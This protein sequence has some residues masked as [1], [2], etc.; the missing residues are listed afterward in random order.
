MLCS[1]TGYKPEALILNSL[2]VFRV[3]ILFL[4]GRLLY[5]HTF[6]IGWTLFCPLGAMAGKGTAVMGNNF[7]ERPLAGSFMSPPDPIRLYEGVILL[8]KHWTITMRKL[9]FLGKCKPNFTYVAVRKLRPYSHFKI[10][11][12]FFK[13]LFLRKI[14][15]FALLFFL[16]PVKGLVKVFLFLFLKL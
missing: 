8:R 13:L 11:R 6:L 4:I 5:E 9:F 2:L 10:I 1:T 3:T 7:Y 14:N 12:P 16:D 15:F